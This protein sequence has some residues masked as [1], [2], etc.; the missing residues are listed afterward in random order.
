VQWLFYLFFYI[1]TVKTCDPIQIPNGEVRY[2]GNDGYILPESSI[3]MFSCFPLY[4]LIGD[5]VKFCGN[6]GWLGVPT[7][8]ERKFLCY[9]LE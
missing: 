6:R 3:A 4:R 1:P 8:C 2:S 9:S 7:I 5:K